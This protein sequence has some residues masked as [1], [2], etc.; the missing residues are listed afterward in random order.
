MARQ[1]RLSLDVFSNGRKVGVY[2]RAADGRITFQY[3]RDWLVRKDSIPVSLSLPLQE[4]PYVGAP[5]S[6][7]FENLLPDNDKIR[8]TI[9]ERYGTQ[10][11]D[12]F[13]L[14]AEIGRDCVGA[15]Q[16]I[17]TGESAPDVQRVEA[18]P[19]T[20]AKIAAQLKG[21]AQ[22]P[23][24]L[25]PGA[26]F[27]ISIA[28]AQEK[29]AFLKLN[30][31]WHRPKGATPT[32]HIMKPPIGPLPNGIDMTKSVENEWLCMTLARELGLPVANTEMADFNGVRA[33]VVERFDRQWARDRSWIIRR[34]QE[35]LLQ[36]L[37]YPPTQKY[38]NERGPGINKIMDILKASDQS[39]ED[40]LIFLRAQVVFWLMG[41]IDG[42]A[43]NF[44][45][46]LA[47][48]GSFRL[49]PLYDIMSVDPAIAMG[50][51]SYGQAKL[52][53]AVGNN[54]H[55]RLDEIVLRHWQQTATRTGVRSESAN[56]LLEEI[57]DSVDRAV[58]QTANRIPENFPADISEPILESVQQRA[59]RLRP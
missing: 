43:K 24:G 59:R 10:G 22:A 49:T 52:A 23:L 18:E 53:M 4:R 6:A 37:G 15:L 36:A 40:R 12:A 41:A 51:L 55:Y 9:A 25:D 44:S 5:V 35:D 33:L 19:V 3:D 46:F 13:S 34:P 54:R 56:R 42:H 17:P 39:E 57:A 32:T 16:F 11:T 7:V 47:P 38:E 29:T 2:T 30:D 1:R 26:D 48:G 8:Q 58:E 50:Q 20:D 28:G 27:R 21:L 14:L 31:K 45:I